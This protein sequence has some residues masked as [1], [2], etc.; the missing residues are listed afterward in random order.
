MGFPHIL[1]MSEL[2]L[3]PELNIPGQEYRD[4]VYID[5]ANVPMLH[6]AKRSCHWYYHSFSRCIAP[7]EEENIGGKNEATDD[8]LPAAETKGERVAV[9]VAGTLQRFMFSST[10]ERLKK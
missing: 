6:I 9:I 4:R 7:E 2:L 1:A 3:S 5:K 8:L 10:I